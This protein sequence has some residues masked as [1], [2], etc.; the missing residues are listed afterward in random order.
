M[1]NITDTIE[2]LRPFGE[3]LYTR[4][5]GRDDL[6]LAPDFLTRAAAARLKAGIAMLESWIRR[7]LILLALEIEPTLSNDDHPHIRYYRER[8]LSSPTH[9]LRIFPSG[10]PFDR[11]RF[12]ALKAAARAKSQTYP[13]H[14]QPSGPI[15]SGPLLSR[16][17][18]LKALI[19]D[20]AARARRLAYHLARRRPGLLRAPPYRGP[21]SGQQFGTEPGALH[22]SF[23]VA[24]LE[25]SR[26]RPPPLGRA[27]NNS[28]RIRQL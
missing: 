5:I 3:Q 22:D 14:H 1:S 20:P 7:A 23:A 4:V 17:A 27:P 10:A 16:L 26:A 9:S 8:K 13:G 11:T 2:E 15:D 19:D 12:E 18:A 25:Q 28:P 24:I 21:H 6:H